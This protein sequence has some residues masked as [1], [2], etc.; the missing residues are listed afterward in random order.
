M[1]FLTLLDDF[2]FFSTGNVTGNAAG[3]S[4]TFIYLALF[5]N[6]PG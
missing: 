6:D 1:I 4:V 2:H 5:F 3:I